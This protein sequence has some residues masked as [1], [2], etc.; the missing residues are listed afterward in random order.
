MLGKNSCKIQVPYMLYLFVLYY[1]HS[2][3]TVLFGT[4]SETERWF[5]YYNTIV[6]TEKTLLVG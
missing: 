1:L 6:V 3:L 5:M 2:L 4:Y